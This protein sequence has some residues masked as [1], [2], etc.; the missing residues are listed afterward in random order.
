MYGLFPRLLRL[1]MMMIYYYYY[2]Y[3][4]Y[5]YYYHDD[6]YDDDRLQTKV[7]FFSWGQDFTRGKQSRE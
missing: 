6:D 2:Y 1:L 4:H 7:V 5:H 3:Y